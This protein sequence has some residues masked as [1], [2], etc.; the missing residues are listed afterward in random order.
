MQHSGKRPTQE[1]QIEFNK[2]KVPFPAPWHTAHGGEPRNDDEWAAHDFKVGAMYASQG[3]QLDELE[4]DWPEVAA[5][6]NCMRG[7][8]QEWFNPTS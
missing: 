1:K 6:V 8:R 3:I 5:N 2:P 4:K 7:Y